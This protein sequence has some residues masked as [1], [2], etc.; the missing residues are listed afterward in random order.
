MTLCLSVCMYVCLSVCVSG[1]SV[2]YSIIC[3]SFPL[4]VYPPISVRCSPCMSVLSC[5][6]SVSLSVFLSYLSVPLCPRLPSISRLFLSSVCFIIIL[7]INQ[8]EYCN[9]KVLWSVLIIILQTSHHTSR[10]RHQPPKKT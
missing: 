10:F 5:S 1:C 9:K 4:S 3:F 2:F 7:L 8:A 6:L